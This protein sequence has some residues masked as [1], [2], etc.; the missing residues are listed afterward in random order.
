MKRSKKRKLQSIS[1]GYIGSWY[2][3]SDTLE[4][5]GRIINSSSSRLFFGKF[6]D[7]EQQD[8]E[9]KSSVSTSRNIKPTQVEVLG[10][11]ENIQ[12]CGLA[13]SAWNLKI[14]SKIE[15][16]N[17]IC[18]INKLVPKPLSRDFLAEFQ[19]MTPYSLKDLEI[20]LLHGTSIDDIITDYSLRT[21]PYQSDEGNS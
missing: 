18:N 9:E 17:L 7:D 16:E 12:G 14:K 1:P 2:H 15:Q 5:V 13:N 19:I 3:I 6:V 20:L 11:P 8:P 4:N 21:S 10:Y